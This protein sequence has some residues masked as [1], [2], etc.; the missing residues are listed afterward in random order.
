MKKLMLFFLFFILLFNCTVTEKPEFVGVDNIK[1]LD[2]NSKTITLSANVIFKNPND[3]GG[4]L[5]TENLNVYINEIEV[6]RFNTES[7]SVP[8]KAEFKIPL[9]VA[10]S[11]DSIIDKNSIE[12]FIGS[13]FSQK[14]KVQYKGEIDYK[15]LGYSST[16][17]VDKT[18]DI[19]MKL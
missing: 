11:T 16:Y 13:L 3:V 4:T 7:F 2:S 6:A 12:G 10:V 19:K 9:T 5:E 17:I 8:K 14:L 15:V 18:Q 1:I